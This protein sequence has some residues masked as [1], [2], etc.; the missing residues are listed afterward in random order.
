MFTFSSTSIVICLLVITL[1]DGNKMRTIIIDTRSEKKVI[2]KDSPKNCM[3]KLF[4]FAPRTLRIPTSLAL[5]VARA[6]VRF[7]K[8]ILAMISTKAAITVKKIM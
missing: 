7:M 4:R 5:L 1:K 2:N 3:A 8:F 6:V